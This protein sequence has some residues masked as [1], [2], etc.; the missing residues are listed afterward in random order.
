MITT[1]PHALVSSDVTRNT[2]TINSGLIKTMQ[3]RIICLLY[4]GVNYFLQAPVDPTSYRWLLALVFEIC[5]CSYFSCC[6]VQH[7]MDHNIILS[8]VASY[9]PQ[10]WIYSV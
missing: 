4:Q 9:C 2:F 5:G 1:R 3:W 6:T 10:P 8:D 7:C